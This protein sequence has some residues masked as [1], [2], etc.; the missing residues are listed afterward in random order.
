MSETC[1]V[2]GS[3]VERPERYWYEMRVPRVPRFYLCNRHGAAVTEHGYLTADNG[4]NPKLV[5]IEYRP[6]VTEIQL[7]E[8]AWPDCEPRTWP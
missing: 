8:G 2:C 1:K 3:H 5:F 7:R 4:R 6:H